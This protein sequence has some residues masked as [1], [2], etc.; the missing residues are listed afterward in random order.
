MGQYDYPAM[1]D[2][3]LNVTRQSALFLVG[4]SQGAHTFFTATSRH[5]EIQKKV[6]LFFAFAPS[7]SST[8]LG[9]IAIKTCVS[10]PRL[11]EAA[12]SR[13]PDRAYSMPVLSPICGRTSF[14]GPCKWIF[15]ELSG[16]VDQVDPLRL[17]VI[18]AHFPGGTSNKNWKHWLQQVHNGTKYF[19][20]GEEGNM[21]AYGTRHPREYD[22]SEF[23]VPTAI[24][25]SPADKLVSSDDIK[26]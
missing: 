18:T 13:I 25:F 26:V 1:I 23:S 20:Y 7:L 16:P 9:S 12:L 5:P 22:F 19:D 6:K 11:I 21:A 15:N 2:Y 8:H 14:Q 24:Y 10:N 3:V 4:H 17:P